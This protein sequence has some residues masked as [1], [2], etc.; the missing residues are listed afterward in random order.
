MN[1]CEVIQLWLIGC[2]EH[3]GNGAGQATECMGLA[4][5]FIAFCQASGAA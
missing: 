2:I 1:M 4:D 3:Y 5:V